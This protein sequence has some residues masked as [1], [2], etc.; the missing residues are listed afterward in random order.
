MV[1]EGTTTFFL[2]TPQ[3]VIQSCYMYTTYVM[4]GQIVTGLMG[5][6]TEAEYS[7]QVVTCLHQISEDK[8]SV[9]GTVNLENRL[10]E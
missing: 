9:T 4:V 2:H 1:H 10:R 6:F 7:G 8:C 3:G 5:E